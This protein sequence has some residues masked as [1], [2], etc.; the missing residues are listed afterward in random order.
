[1]SCGLAKT[2]LISS[3]RICSSSSAHARTNGSLVATVSSLRGHRHRQ[4]AVALGVGVRHRLRDRDQ[5]DLQRIDVMVRNAELA[6]EPFDQRSRAS[7]ACAVAISERHFWSAINSSGCVETLR[8]RARE[9]VGVG[10]RDEPVGDHQLE[11]V[12]EA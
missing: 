4:D 3:C 7:A 11:D 12:F 8:A 2:S 10:G 1:M 9:R 5:V 6:G